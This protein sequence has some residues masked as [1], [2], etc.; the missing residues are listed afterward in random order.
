[1][2]PDAVPDQ[3]GAATNIDDIAIA[4]HQIHI[5]NVKCCIIT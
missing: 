2:M 4:C 5:I 1:M 3:P